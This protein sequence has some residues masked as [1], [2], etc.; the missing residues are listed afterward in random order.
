MVSKKESDVS[1]R[2]GK[3]EILV[4]PVFPESDGVWCAIVRD[5]V[6]QVAIFSGSHEKCRDHAYT[7][8]Q[9]VRE[10]CIQARKHGG[11][12]IAPEGSSQTTTNTGA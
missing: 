10:A 1:L 9:I 4:R 12:T 2:V 6:S 8:F 3:V 11:I 5:G 7:I